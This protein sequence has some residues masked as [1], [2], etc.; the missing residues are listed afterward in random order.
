MNVSY[1]FLAWFSTCVLFSLELKSQLPF[2]CYLSDSRGTFF[3]Y[4]SFISFAGYFVIGL[5]SE[6]YK[7]KTCS[8]EY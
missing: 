4:R 2:R 7:A 3:K 5:F 1:V 6:Y 8:W